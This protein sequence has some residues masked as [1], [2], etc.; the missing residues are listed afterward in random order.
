M[1]GSGLINK[2]VKRLSVVAFLFSMT[3]VAALF[4]TF[5]AW[6]ISQLDPAQ[7]E[8]VSLAYAPRGASPTSVRSLTA[9]QA[10]DVHL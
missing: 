5:N 8:I 1:M 6:V 3:V 7:E 2:I 4:G 9:R 10:G